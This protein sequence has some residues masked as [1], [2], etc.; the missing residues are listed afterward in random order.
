M[1]YISIPP[2]QKESNYSQLYIT[3]LHNSLYKQ[4]MIET[5]MKYFRHSFYVTA[6]LEY[7][8][9]L[10]LKFAAKKDC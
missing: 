4:S 9:P 8:D 7:L 6:I 2:L 5:C 10:Q 1:G 3:A